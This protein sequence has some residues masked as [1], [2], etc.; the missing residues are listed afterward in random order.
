M[1]Q[2][3]IFDVYTGKP[4]PE[5]RKSLAFAL[6]YQ[7][8][9]RTLKDEEVNSLNQQVLEGIEKEFGASWRK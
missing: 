9:D 6:K 8:M 1:V 4:I 7:A 3:D 5:D 2:V